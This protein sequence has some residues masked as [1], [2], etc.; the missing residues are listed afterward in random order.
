MR[1][2]LV[3]PDDLSQAG[4]GRFLEYFTGVG[5]FADRPVLSPAKQHSVE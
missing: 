2:C 3:T 1:E 4:G 5:R